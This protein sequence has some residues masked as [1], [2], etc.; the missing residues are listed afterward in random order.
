M[1]RVVKGHTVDDLELGGGDRAVRRVRRVRR[2]RS[3]A[4]IKRNSTIVAR[5][6]PQK[7]RNTA[8]VGADPVDGAVS[9]VRKLPITL[10]ESYS[11]KC[12]QSRILLLLGKTPL[13][14]WSHSLH[15][16]VEYMFSL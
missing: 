10:D 4:V 5:E 16:R 14:L 11:C 8:G 7:I 1:S 13:D 12:L 2:V 3:E 6:A 15:R 9:S